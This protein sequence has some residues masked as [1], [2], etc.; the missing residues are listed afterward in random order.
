MNSK[1]IRKQLLAAVAM[2]LVAAVALGSS[3]YAWFVASGSVEATGMKVQ[4]QTESGLLIRGVS[5]NDQDQWTGGTWATSATAVNTNVVSL[6]PTSTIDLAAWYMA[7]SNASNTAL[8]QQTVTEQNNPYTPVSTNMLDTYRRVDTFAI[9]S[10]SGA[11]LEDVKLAVKSVSATTTTTNTGA[12]NQ[13]IRIGVKM[14]TGAGRAADTEGGE[15]G[16]T[17]YIFAPNTTGDKFVLKA[18]YSSGNT[19]DEYK[20][21]SNARDYL[22]ISDDTIPYAETGVMVEVYTWYEGED[23]QCMTDNITNDDGSALSADVLNVTV[24]FEKVDLT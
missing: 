1:A 20:E 2:V 17:F 19:L 11:D 6:R 9:R 4:A 22:Y 14:V 5:K 21:A 10:A 7:S 18:N 23:D 24:V 8:K 12:L 3:T 15:T 13:A 16:S